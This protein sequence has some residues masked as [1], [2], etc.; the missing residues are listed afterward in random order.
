[1]VRA[2]QGTCPITGAWR[3]CGRARFDRCSNGPWDLN[4][5]KGNFNHCYKLPNFIGWWEC[6]LEFIYI[7]IYT[8]I[9]SYHIYIYI[10]IQNTH[11]GQV[12][13]KQGK[14]LE[15]A[16]KKRIKANISVW[17]LATSMEFSAKNCTQELGFLRKIGSGTKK[18][19][20]LRRNQ[21]V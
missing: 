2:R 11:I 12:T 18:R 3:R 14:S 4:F 20:N 6:K 19:W 16:T 15:F 8:Y 10:Y 21:W 13:H 5:L 1:M 9:I 7:Y 17:V